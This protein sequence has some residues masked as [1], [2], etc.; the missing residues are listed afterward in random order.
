MLVTG[1]L[2]A[3]RSLLATELLQPRFKGT[4]HV[5]RLEVAALR[6]Q[7]VGWIRCMVSSIG[8]AADGVL[9]IKAT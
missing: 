9:G 1:S 8:G 5:T 4:K 3:T 7:R 2:L 6:L